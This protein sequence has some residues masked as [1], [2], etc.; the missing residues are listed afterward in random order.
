MSYL[1]KH[2]GTLA[3]GL[4]IIVTCGV[5]ALIIY[6][7]VNTQALHTIAELQR[8]VPAFLPETTEPINGDEFCP[9]DTILWEVGVD[10]IPVGP[11][12]VITEWRVDGGR[13]EGSANSTFYSET[14][15]LVLITPLGF[16]D[17]KEYLTLLVDRTVPPFATRYLGRDLTIRVILT[18][19]N[20]GWS[21]YEVKTKLKDKCP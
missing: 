18:Y 8:Q 10:Y 13:V 20:D 7:T 19:Y 12:S 15:P 5:L 4:S 1:I 11:H 6:F 21:Y 9:G 16:S 3:F 17:N 2:K 14:T